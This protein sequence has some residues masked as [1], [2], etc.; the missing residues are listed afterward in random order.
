LTAAL[1]LRLGVRST[2]DWCE[3]TMLGVAGALSVGTM[4][5]VNL[6]LGSDFRWLLILPVVAWSIA[7]LLAARTMVRA[8][9][10][11]AGGPRDR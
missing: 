10:V 2:T 7:I 11:P 3:L 5:A 4:S 1:A 8:M 6:V 9:P